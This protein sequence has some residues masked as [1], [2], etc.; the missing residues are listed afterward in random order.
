MESNITNLQMGPKLSGRNFFVSNPLP[1]LY[2]LSIKSDDDHIFLIANFDSTRKGGRDYKANLL[3][4]KE[5]LKALDC[6]YLEMNLSDISNFLKKRGSVNIFEAL[7]L[8]AYQRMKRVRKSN[9]KE[10]LGIIL[11][12]A[13]WFLIFKRWVK[14]SEI[15][16]VR[17]LFLWKRFVSSLH[18]DFFFILDPINSVK[19]FRGKETET[20]P[21]S[22]FF[23]ICHRLEKLGVLNSYFSVQYDF[24]SPLI[25]LS[26]RE[27]I[28]LHDLISTYMNLAGD[29]ESLGPRD[30]MLH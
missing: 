30:F 4:C 9:A 22:K 1:L 26:P 12:E 16:Q 15:W 17:V 29:I 14:I 5:I 23:E 7:V 3:F 8:R 6:P 11:L 27:D 24:S 2:A 28:S 20:I 18:P 10:K 19:K 21:K 25:V 13:D